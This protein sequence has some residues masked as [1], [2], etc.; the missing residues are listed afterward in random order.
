[1]PLSE[2]ICVNRSLEDRS[3]GEDCW[4]EEKLVWSLRA[5]MSSSRS[6]ASALLKTKLVGVIEPGCCG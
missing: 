6:K 4:E 1:M 3:I 5:P 2:Y